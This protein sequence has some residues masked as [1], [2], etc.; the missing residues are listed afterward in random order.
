MAKGRSADGEDGGVERDDGEMDE[1][2]LCITVAEAEVD[3]VTEVV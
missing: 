1:E 3:C 2:R